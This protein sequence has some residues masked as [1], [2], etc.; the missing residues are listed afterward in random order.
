[1]K[2]GLNY[3][4][5]ECCKRY[6]DTRKDLKRIVDKRYSE[7]NKEKLMAQKKEYYQNNKEV[8]AVKNKEYVHRNFNKTAEYKKKYR[9]KNIEH[10]KEYMR[11]YVKDRFDSDDYFRFHMNLRRRILH[12]FKLNTKNGKTKSCIE[13]GINFEKIYEKI[14]PRPSTKHQ[15]DHIIPLDAF[16][17]YDADHVRLAHTP[18][19]L[20]WLINTENSRK[21]NLIIWELIESNSEL[22][23]IC[24]IIGLNK[25]IDNAHS[26]C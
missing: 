17:L 13:Y 26:N 3:R 25:N 18:A 16:D 20:R 14:G 7:K 1:M 10:I 11:S 24:K 6:S 4:C 2:D 19:N 15:L 5:N 8:L 12:A 9:E 22:L 21:K 23:E